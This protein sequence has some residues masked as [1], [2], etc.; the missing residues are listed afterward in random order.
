MVDTAFDPVLFFNNQAWKQTLRDLY[1]PGFSLRFV[2]ISGY[3]PCF[4]R[5]EASGY[6]VILTVVSDYS[7]SDTPF[8][9]SFFY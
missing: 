2:R 7:F 5:D 1:I 9:C 8:I 3:I 6:P 4:S